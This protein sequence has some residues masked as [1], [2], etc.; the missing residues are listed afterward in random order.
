MPGQELINTVITVAGTTRIPEDTAKEQIGITV[1]GDDK[2]KYGL[3]FSKKDKTPTAAH[4]TWEEHD[5][6]VGDKIGLGYAS[7]A[8][9]CQSKGK[10]INYEQRTIRFIEVNPAGDY[11]IINASHGDTVADVLKFVKFLAEDLL[12]SYRYQL[13]N[14]NV[15]V[16]RQHS[17]YNELSA[18]LKGYTYFEE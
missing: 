1:M 7:E 16:E 13:S 14:V 12:E 6:K 2:K 18:G 10:T 4:L 5:I 17:Y 8:K 9:S 11:E 15:G 3:F